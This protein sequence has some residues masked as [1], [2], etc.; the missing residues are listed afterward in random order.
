MAE[1]RKRIEVAIYRRD[2]EAQEHVNDVDIG[3]LLSKLTVQPC[4]FDKCGRKR[5]GVSKSR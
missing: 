5:V 4:Q 1:V 3:P 2:P